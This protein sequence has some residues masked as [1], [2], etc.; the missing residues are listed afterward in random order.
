MTTSSDSERSLLLRFL[1]YVI[2]S[3]VAMWVFSLYTMV[4]G[5]VVARFVGP[6]ALSSV[7]LAAPVTGGLFAIGVIIAVGTSTQ[8]AIAFG[9]KNVPR[10]QRLFATGWWILL[11]LSLVLALL[12][13]L[14]L[15]SL[16]RLLGAHGERQL[17]TTA[18]LRIILLFCPFMALSYFLEYMV[19]VDGFPL[20]ATAVVSLCAVL[21]IALDLLFVGVFDLGIQGAAWATGIAQVGSFLLFLFHILGK[22]GV[23]R[24]SLL[25]DV[26]AFF[27]MMVLG[28]SDFL[29]EMSVGVIVFFMN[30]ALPPAL[31]E[32]SLVAYTVISYVSTL[33]S[34]TFMGLSQGLQPLVSHALG[35]RRGE[36]I[37][38]LVPMAFFFV[39]GLGILLTSLCGHPDFLI[40]LFLDKKEVLSR[41]MA[42]DG[43]RLYRFAYPLLGL[44]L[45]L[46]GLFTALALPRPA[47][48]LSLMRT[49]PALFIALF[50][51]KGE[52]V[53]LANAAAEGMT[54]CLGVFL[55]LISL[56]L[57]EDLRELLLKTS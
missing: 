52:R 54:F 39:V 48:L 12:G 29:A 42:A 21:N 50:F 2:P 36:E 38:R 45:L 55:V 23:L 30:H 22:R 51:M 31:G 15:P 19:K 43:L 25:V 7:N 56:R 14:F 26:S 6:V 35:E 47:I 53:W 24:L 5:L 28:I 18:Y 8:V 11:G 16:A 49:G 17:L 40:D 33:V 3:V 57:R 44:N 41:Q 34:M 1:R 32:E 13:I 10:A 37:R 4:D 9:E 20:L 46:G 27:R